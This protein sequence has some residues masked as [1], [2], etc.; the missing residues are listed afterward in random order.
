MLKIVRKAYIDELEKGI[1]S[2]RRRAHDAERHEYETKES[3]K[4]I[5]DVIN[6][7]ISNSKKL[8]KNQIIDKLKE[9]EK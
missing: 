9:L 4:A 1:A 5:I 3:K 8:T 2:Y 6:N 7:I